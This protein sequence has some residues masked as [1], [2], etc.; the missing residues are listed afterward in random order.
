MSIL[1]YVGIGL[2][3]A[4]ALFFAIVLVLLRRVVPTNMVHIV[5][6]SKATTSYGKGK[7]EGNTYYAWPAWVPKIG[8]TV[9]EFPESIFKVSLADYE[10]YDQARLPFMVDVTAFFRVDHS[11]TAAQRVASF[12]ELEDQL[13]AVL[14]GAV[15][16]ILATNTLEQ[17]M[18][19]RSELGKQFTN[20]VDEQIKEWGVKTVKTIEFMDLRDSKVSESKVIHNIMAKEQ[21]RIDKESRVAVANNK[22][23]AQLVEIDAQRTVDVQRQDAEQQV[24]LRKAEKDKN[25]GIANEQSKQEV[26]VQAAVTTEKVMAV[27]KV[28]LERAAEIQMQVQITQANAQKQTQVIESEAVLITTQNSAKGV[29][30]ES[31]GQLAATQN[32]AKGIQAEGEANAKAQELLLLAPVT[33]QVTLAKEIGTN[34]GYQSYLVTLKQVDA[35]QA[36]GIAMAAALGEADLKI[37]S[38]GG[39]QGE[40]MKGAGGLM[41]M[42]TAQGGT[43]IAGMLAGLAQT[44]EGKAVLN[45]ITNGKSE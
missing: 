23:A 6:S 8:V 4:F 24:G 10:A 16:R 34:E 2:S 39:G 13:D 43:S 28:E 15:R 21:S 35:N 38:S 17:I 45:R 26:Q 20:E 3:V 7:A 18:E 32:R 14:K 29:Q 19:A 37:I 40:I 5:Q 25:V 1:A 36:V 42:F 11:E 27:K 22:Q 9:T 12:S 44:D 30:I 41:D 33:A 31:E